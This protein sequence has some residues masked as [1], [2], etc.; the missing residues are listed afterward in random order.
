M[1]IE[2]LADGLG[3]TEGPVC[4]PGHRVACT[5]ISHGCVYLV[6]T[7]V[8]A[9]ER[10][11]TGGGP[12][13][14]AVSPDGTL[15]V[16]QNGGVFGGSG[17]AEPGVQVIRGG[18][19]QY[20]TDGMGAPND[21][22][23]GPDGRLWVT[24]TRS[25]IDPANPGDGR[26]GWVWAVDT[27][28]GAKELMIDNGPVFVNGLAFTLDGQRFMVTATLAAQ[29]WSFHNGPTGCR[30]FDTAQ[31]IH[32]FDDGWPDGMAVSPRGDV[33]VALTAADRLDVI[34]ATGRRVATLPF[35]AG[36]LPTNLCL[37]CDRPDE[38][39]VTAAHRQSLLRIRL[40]DDGD[41]VLA[42]DRTPTHS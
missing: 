40:C 24:D 3:F 16:A 25:G 17:P 42:P 7:V 26:P 30:G 33:W 31:L 13:G 5:S 38:L 29:L 23:L 27:A 20:L 41:P 14:L 28:N 35:P 32:A 11:D 34:T 4:L 1:N 10:I 2:V 21:L 15:Y 22:V 9:V 19:V 39:F 8:G 37:N 18:R 12:N 6:D 36:S